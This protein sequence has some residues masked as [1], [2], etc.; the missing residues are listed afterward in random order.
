MRAL[1]C[2]EGDGWCAAHVI[3]AVHLSVE[4]LSVLLG[5]PKVFGC[6]SELVD[7]VSE[8]GEV[9]AHIFVDIGKAERPAGGGRRWWRQRAAKDVC[10]SIE[11]MGEKATE[12]DSVSTCITVCLIYLLFIRRIC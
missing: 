4:G 11:E 6:S 8:V 5:E 12:G 2:V 1:G 9:Q 10:E 7:E 3:E